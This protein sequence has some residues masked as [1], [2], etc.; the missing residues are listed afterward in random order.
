M[1][2]RACSPVAARSSSVSALPS[3]LAARAVNTPTSTALS[4]S[5]ETVKLWPRPLILVMS[6]GETVVG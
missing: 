4:S 6:S 5:L 1:A 2:E 3:A